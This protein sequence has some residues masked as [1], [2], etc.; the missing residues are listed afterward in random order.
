MLFEG[1]GGPP[2]ERVE[3]LV[4]LSERHFPEPIPPT[5]RKLNPAKRCR[6]CYRREHIRKESRYHCPDC[7]SQP[8]L[9]IYPCFRIYHT[10]TDIWT[11]LI[12]TDL[13]GTEIFSTN[14][15]L[16]F[17]IMITEH[18]WCMHTC[19]TLWFKLYWALLRHPCIQTGHLVDNYSALLRR[20]CIFVFVYCLYTCYG[21]KIV[22]VH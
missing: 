9:C 1:R 11:E 6:V 21:F 14:R 20:F 17:D 18:Y 13:N 3:A 22:D 19:R 5:E 4:R 2:E 10:E 12:W 16:W 8:G 7:P 15:T